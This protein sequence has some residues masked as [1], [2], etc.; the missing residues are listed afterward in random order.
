MSADESEEGSTHRDC[1][2]RE[3]GSG[4]DVG[5]PVRT[6][7]EASQRDDDGDRHGEEHQKA[8]DGRCSVDAHNE[9]GNAEQRCCARHV[10]GGGER[11]AGLEK[12]L[13]VG[14]RTF[15]TDERF[16]YRAGDR[17]PRQRFRSRS[18]PERPNAHAMR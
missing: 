11:V 6:Q 10:T 17:R 5:E 4:D 7:V 13:D 8:F 1:K 14:R 15:A 2:R 9:N 12:N 3:N 16:D 18:S